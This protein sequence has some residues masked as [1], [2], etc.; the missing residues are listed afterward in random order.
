MLRQAQQ[1]GKTDINPS[2][3]PF[4]KLGTGSDPELQD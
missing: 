3:R 2:V 4:G 1:N